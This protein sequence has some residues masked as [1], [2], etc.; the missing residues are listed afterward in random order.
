MPLTDN[1]IFGLLTDLAGCLCAQINDE[2]NGLQGVCFCGVMPGEAV[3]MDYVDGCDDDTCGMAYVRLTTLYPSAT[4]GQVDQR[5]GNC[6]LGLGIDIEV[7][8]LRCISGYDDSGTLPDEAEVLAKVQQQTADAFAMIR[9][10]NCCASLP[11][12]EFIMGQYAPVGPMGG[13][14]GGTITLSVGI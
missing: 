12:K 1:R 11:S 10:I 5:P 14:V 7:G 13:V 3:A 9:A 8:I 4:I 2:A 6:G